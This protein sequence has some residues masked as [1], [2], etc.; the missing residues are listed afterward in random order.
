MIKVLLIEDDTWLGESYN[1]VLQRA[2]CS[3]TVVGDG[4]TAMQQID[5]S[6]P[7]VI[8]ADVMLRGQTIFTL[9]HELQTYDDTKTIP[10][11][12]CTGLETE[13]MTPERLHSYGV[14]LVLQKSTL[15]PEELVLAVQECVS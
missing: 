9:L 1:L 2:N 4:E 7:D 15:S 10:V 14:A 8:V 5:A 11:V 6:K 3:V 13:T 12:L